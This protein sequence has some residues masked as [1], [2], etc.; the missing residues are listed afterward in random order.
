M[1][2]AV[3]VL[4]VLLHE[5]SVGTLTRTAGD[6]TLFAFNSRYIDDETRPTLG[7]SF[8]TQDGLLRTQLRPYSMRLMPFFSN[9]LPEGHLRQYLA[10]RGE[11]H[12]DREFFLLWLLGEDLPGALR[13]R[14]AEGDVLPPAYA[15]EATAE[16]DGARTDPNAS[17]ALRFSLAGIQLKFSAIAKSSGGLTIPAKGVGGSW[18]VKLASERYD[19]VP[20]NEYSMMTLAAKLGM[21][22]PRVKLVDTREIENLPSDLGRL[23]DH[24]ALAIERFDHLPDGTHV[25]MEDFA[26]VFDLYPANK[27]KRPSS[28]NVAQVL[29]IESSQED[30]RE[31]IRRLVFNALIGNSDMHVKN[32]SLIY[33]D[34]RSA[35]LSPA[36]DFVSTTA[37]ISDEGSALEFSRSRYYKDLTLDELAHMADRA[38][39]PEHLV[40]EAAKET[41]QGFQEVWR[42]ER[43]NLPLSQDVIQAVERQ[44]SL[45]PL[46]KH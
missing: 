5:Q 35:R 14:P 2:D 45:V 6:R 39:L 21:N 31:F 27:Y 25:H 29:G 11:V 13:V 12:P 33:P 26:Q 9:L 34:R 8:K 10:E 19:G 17:N 38:N 15:R 40:L 44:L 42:Q 32:W 41:V 3:S 4:E 43:S 28:M 7:L 22:V 23:R 1:N 20:R 16:S 30:V 46:A 37:Y 24:E 18:I 36:Y